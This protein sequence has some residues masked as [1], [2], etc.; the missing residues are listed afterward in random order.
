[1]R[2]KRSVPSVLLTLV[3]HRATKDKSA[4]NSPPTRSRGPAHGLGRVMA[5]GRWRGSA[6][7]AGDRGAVFDGGAVE[8]LR[9]EAVG[10]GAAGG[11]AGA[12]RHPFTVRLFVRRRAA[13]ARDREAADAV[14]GVDR[15]VAA[16]ADEDVGA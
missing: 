13:A 9:V 1:Q 7:E 14:A 16:V 6:V 5:G 10:E 2:E 4:R 8:G 12:L 3:A 15:G 11:L